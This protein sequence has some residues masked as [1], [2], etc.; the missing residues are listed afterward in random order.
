MIPRTNYGTFF[1]LQDSFYPVNQYWKHTFQIKF[2]KD[3]SFPDLPLPC[4]HNVNTSLCDH[5]G[6]SVQ[7][8][9]FIRKQGLHA[10]HT[11]MNEI[12]AALPD[13]PQGH[14][15]RRKR[16][17]LPF[18][19]KVGHSLF[20]LATD[21][22]IKTITK[23]IEQLEKHQGV[24]FQELQHYNFSSIMQLMD[25]RMT[26]MMTAVQFNHHALLSLKQ[27]LTANSES[28]NN[29]LTSIITFLADSIRIVTMLELKVN[30]FLDGILDMTKGQLSQHIVSTCGKSC[31]K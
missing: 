5:L 29:A 6:R 22:D 27:S 14:I 2:P 4:G 12:Y 8:I 13:T 1:N 9:N 30:Q 18:L 20:G 23:H 26:N 11:T 10:V 19:G 21:N 31:S 28:V 16:S 25:Q 3:I 7:H 17:L 15:P 24:L